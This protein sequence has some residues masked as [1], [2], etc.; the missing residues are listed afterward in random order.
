MKETPEF[1]ADASTAVGTLI[2]GRLDWKQFLLAAE[3]LLPV[4]LTQPIPYP[5]RP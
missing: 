2:G 1:K 4:L 3:M 5:A